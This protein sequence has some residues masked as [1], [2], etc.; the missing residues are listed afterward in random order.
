MRTLSLAIL[1]I[2][3]LSS[4][5]ETISEAELDDPGRSVEPRGSSSIPLAAQVET[6][7]E[8]DQSTINEELKVRLPAGYL[9]SQAV[10]VNLDLDE[11][12]EQIIVFKRGDEADDFIRILV[13][14]FDPIRNA[15]IRAWEGVTA[16][17]SVRSFSVY[18]DDLIGDLEQEIVAIGINATG[19]QTVDV[20]RRTS[21]IL[22]LG[23]S[24]VP[25]LSIAADVTIEIEEV[26]R[27]EAYEAMETISAPS[28]PI[29]AERRNLDSENEFDT[30]RTTYF[31]DFPSRSYVEGRVEEVSGDSIADGQLRDLFAGTESEFEAFLAGPWYRSSDAGEVRLAFFGVRDR[32]IVFHSGFLQQSFDWLESTKTVY[33]RGITLF[34]ANESIR[35]VRRYV[36]V[37]VSDLNRITVAIQ[38]TDG[39]DGTYERLTGSLQSDVL[40]QADGFLLSQIAPSGLFR[41]DDGVELVFA[42]P[43]FSLTEGGATSHGGYALYSVGD[44]VVLSLR[45]LDENRLPVSSRTYRVAYEEERTD[46]RVV[47][48]MELLPGAV[49]IA[50][51]YAT[52]GVVLTLEQVQIVETDE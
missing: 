41:G 35:S 14:T 5:V 19:E 33:G 12:D 38:G 10:T 42:S 45:T 11:T 39:L 34:V 20:F 43:E 22:G 50:G 23:L 30:I 27:S 28:F 48:R 29:I 36:S 49:G 8:D 16:A 6:P 46:D 9:A 52:D 15:W 40:A 21:D 24:Y 26:A 18:T 32:T 37:S 2:A 7:A 17:T 1:A 4:C 44:D 3:I 47:R 51:F 25:I 13:V 31:W